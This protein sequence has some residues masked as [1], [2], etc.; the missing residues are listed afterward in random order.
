MVRGEIVR[1][2][3]RQR[4]RGHEQRSARPAVVVQSDDLLALSTVLVAPTSRSAQP[5]TFRPLIDLSGTATRVLT[6]QVRAV[7]AQSLGGSL[8]STQR[9]GAPDARRCARAGV[10]A[11]RLRP[12]SRVYRRLRSWDAGSA[13]RPSR[14]WARE[15]GAARSRRRPRERGLTAGGDGRSATSHLAGRGEACGRCNCSVT[16]GRWPPCTPG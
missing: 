12:G 15:R 11:A 4:A 7:D 3:A 9:R 16:L 1:V 10:R 14:A 13:R 2:P 8:G 6:D 5:A